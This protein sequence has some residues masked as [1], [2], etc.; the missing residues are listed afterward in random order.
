MNFTLLVTPAL[1]VLGVALGEVGCAVLAPWTP[2]QDAPAGLH[3]FG[4]NL[5]SFGCQAGR[6]DAPL[7]CKGVC[8]TAP[9]TGGLGAGLGFGRR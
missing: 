9:S 1:L 5:L 3:V 7:C 4:P 2:E 8:C 6:T